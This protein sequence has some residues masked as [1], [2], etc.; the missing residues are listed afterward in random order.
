MRDK[1][2]FDEFSFHKSFVEIFCKK[3]KLLTLI[4][5]SLFFLT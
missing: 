4:R 5:V 2:W 1:I 3:R